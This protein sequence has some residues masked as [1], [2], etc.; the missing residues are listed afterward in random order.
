MNFIAYAVGNIIGPHLFVSTE[1]PPYRSG[2]LACICCFATAIPL[3]FALRC[4]YVRENAR[5]DRLQMLE[6][7]VGEQH[8][9]DFVD[10]TD[11]E[12][13]SFRYAL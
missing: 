3:C 8:H 12:N 2:M 13:L 5:R 11:M 10:R 6:G 1:S 4:H 9:D 7:S